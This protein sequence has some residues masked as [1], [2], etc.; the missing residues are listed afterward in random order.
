MDENSGV[1]FELVNCVL[2]ENFEGENG[3]I[4]NYICY[5]IFFGVREENF[6]DNSVLISD[7]KV[8]R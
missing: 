2:W 8:F 1:L 5:D 4:N 6:F 3:K 7:F